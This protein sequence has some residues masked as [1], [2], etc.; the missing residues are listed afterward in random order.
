V[1]VASYHTSS[2]FISY[3][4]GGMLAG[5]NNPPLHLLA[6]G[7]SGVNGAYARGPA[8]TFPSTGYLASNFWVDVTFSPT[9]ANP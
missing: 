4:E 8:G 5:V 2:G 6:D 9:T 3:D 7:V 1:Y